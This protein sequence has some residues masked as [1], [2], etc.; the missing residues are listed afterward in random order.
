MGKFFDRAEDFHMKYLCLLWGHMPFLTKCFVIVYFKQ[1]KSKPMQDF[2]NLQLCYQEIYLNYISLSVK[3]WNSSGGS[4]RFRPT[5]I[6]MTRNKN[7][8]SCASQHQ[9]L[10]LL[11]WNALSLS[12]GIM[13]MSI[14]C[15]IQTRKN[16]LPQMEC[17]MAMRA[18]LK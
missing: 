18:E 15:R 16:W 17:K 1:W 11:C 3:T 7:G 9:K 14:V 12:L 13:Y 6:K 2:Q 8:F 10:G 5:K 4:I